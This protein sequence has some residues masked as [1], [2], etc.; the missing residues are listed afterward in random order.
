[1]SNLIM[2]QF[3]TTHS[4]FM[5]EIK[6]LDEKQL[7]TQPEGFNNTIHWH[8]G[9][10]LTTNEQFLFGFPENTEHLPERYKD[11]FGYGSKPADWPEDVPS[12]DELAGQLTDQLKRIK[13][14]PE[15][16][17]DEKLPK[18]VLGAQTY[19]ELAALAAFHEGN[20]V[21]RINAMKKILN[22]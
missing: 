4:A 14:I 5:G 10:V 7:E 13:Q 16:K 18:T 3:N 12:A 11:L 19:G 15:E 6:D 22:K 9:H 8:I 20:H 2:T 1:M 17:L 21:G